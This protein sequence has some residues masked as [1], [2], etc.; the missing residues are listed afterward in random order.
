MKL[1]QA[2][3]RCELGGRDD[4]VAHY[5]ASR[6]TNDERDAFEE[7]L[8]RCAACQD[9]VLLALSVRDALRARPR[10][11][12]HTRAR[13]VIATLAAALAAVL[14]VVAV[15]PVTQRETDVAALAGIGEP[16]A[17]LG[18]S[19]R[20][21]APG[22]SALESAMALYDQGRWTDAGEALRAAA[23]LGAPRDV[24]AFFLGASALMTGDAS[25]ADSA[26]AA[27]DALGPGPYQ[28]EAR[29][30]RAKALLRLQRAADALHALQT[31]PE[32]TAIGAHALALSDSLR[33]VGVR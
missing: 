4:R 6:L 23:R 7:H 14:V 9:E 15:W 11:R 13:V 32:A 28:G 19:V 21:N 2:T 12:V 25:L 17:Y 30:Y 5:V 29:F 26:F 33:A 31:V 8:L 27:V 16:P 20:A 10:L 22:D 1:T 3:L 24:A 18:A